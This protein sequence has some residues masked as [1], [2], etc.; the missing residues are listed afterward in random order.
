MNNNIDILVYEFKKSITDEIN[1]SK[2]PL[3]VKVMIIKELYDA[4]NEAS[5][6]Q[7]AKQLEYFKQNSINKA[8]EE[9][10]DDNATI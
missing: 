5:K 10:D 6:R 4:V 9:K 8:E 7:L 3:S 2:L 1:K